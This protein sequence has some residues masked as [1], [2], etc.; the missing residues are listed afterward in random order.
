VTKPTLPNKISITWI[1]LTPFLVLIGWVHQ[2]A[3]FLVLL[4]RFAIT[5]GWLLWPERVT[6]EAPFFLSM[7]GRPAVGVVVSHNKMAISQIDFLTTK[8]NSAGALKDT[9][10][11]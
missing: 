8:I 3:F 11:D 5:G 6:P 7:L 9:P 1:V 10:G 2:G 4:T